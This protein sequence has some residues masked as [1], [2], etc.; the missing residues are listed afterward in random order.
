VAAMTPYLGSTNT[1][2][3]SGGQPIGSMRSVA[4]ARLS[5]RLLLGRHMTS[6]RPLLRVLIQEPLS[7]EAA[8]TATGGITE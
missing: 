1:V 4:Y 6:A 8:R 7:L 5:Q 3:I 2:D